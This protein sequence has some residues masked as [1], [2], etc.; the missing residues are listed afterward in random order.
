MQVQ[1]RIHALDNLRAIAIIAMA[2]YHLFFDLHL[3][4]LINI[5]LDN[6]F[7]TLLVTIFGFIFIT[8]AGVTSS[9]SR[10]LF[11]QSI[12]LLLF[13][14]LISVVTYLFDSQTMV[15]FGIL[16]LFATLTFFL[17]IAQH[18]QLLLPSLFSIIFIAWFF[19]TQIATITGF[20][21]VNFA[22]LDYYPLVPWGIPFFF[23]YIFSSYITRIAQ[24]SL[25]NQ[26]ITIIS[27][28]GKYS[29]LIYLIH[30]P[31]IFTIIFLY[32]KMQA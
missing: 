25:I 32:S 23:G 15:R 21:S 31:I 8:L 3:F 13:A 16:H 18:K 10:H 24:S 27:S 4:G 20:P 5:N 6:Q 30:Q 1:S 11:Q 2:V 9:L 19:P 26:K 14:S 12:K 22:S 28:I 17:Y 29:L 7:I